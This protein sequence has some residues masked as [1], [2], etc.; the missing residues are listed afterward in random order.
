MKTL[1]DYGIKLRSHRPGNYKVVCPAC[2][3]TRKKKNDPCLSVSIDSDLSGVWNCHHCEWTGSTGNSKPKRKKQYEKPSFSK[4][5]TVKPASKDD[6]IIKWFATRGISAQ[7]LA[8][9]S[10]TTAIEWM[11][12]SGKEVPVIAFPFF[13]D[14][15][16]VNCKFRGPDKDFKQTKN[17]EKILYGLDDLSPEEETL[18]IVE[19]E[20]DKL[21]FAEIGIYNVVSVPDGA[22]KKVQDDTPDQEDD[23]KFS[24]VWNCRD[25]LDSFNKII[26]A[27]D[28]DGPGES[29]KEELARRLG[30]ERCSV[31]EWPDGCKDSNEVLLAH[32]KEGLENLITEA[33]PYPIGDIFKVNDFSSDVINLFENGLQQGAS[34]G[35]DNLDKL[36]SIHKKMISIVTGSSGS[37][38]SE[39]L[40]AMCFNLAK[41]HG[42]K[43]AMCSLE[44]TKEI[45]VSKFATKYSNKPFFG[46]H[47]MTKDELTEAM[48]W[49][50][51]HFEFIHPDGTTTT[52]I[53]WVL[54]KAKAAVMR[55]GINGLVLDPYNCF[56]HNIKA[57]GSETNYISGILQKLKLFAESHDIHIWFVAHPA[58]QYRNKSDGQIPVPTLNDISGSNSWWT[59]ADYGLVLHRKRDEQGQ[60]STTVEVHV[61]KIRFQPWM[62]SEG[63]CHLALD[64]ATG[65]YRPDLYADNGI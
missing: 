55:D 37:G 49:T 16:A 9:Y 63:M 6:A 32:G 50:N 20:V 24:Y 38:K 47:R 25:F 39:F 23:T 19:G 42:W 13:R 59:K 28:G 7:T 60:R 18:I 1:S 30:K 21:S 62:G 15:E 34:P 22:P 33:S 36:M 54:E 43:F 10:I 17:A 31:V 8:R 44:N 41:N 48:Q 2:S 40:D 58:K 51:N 14:G 65:R 12:K 52:S 26:L 5:E 64:Q 45:H 3:S 46:D 56:E 4:R 35:W 27:T 29:L 61:Q 53:D 11:P 57:A